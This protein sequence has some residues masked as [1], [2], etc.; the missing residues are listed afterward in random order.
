MFR[1]FNRPG[2]VSQSKVVALH[3][4]A[5]SPAS[6]EQGVAQFVTSEERELVKRLRI[7]V[8]EAKPHPECG[9]ASRGCGADAKGRARDDGHASRSKNVVVHPDIPR[10]DGEASPKEGG[11]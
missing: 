4:A 5:S 11:A 2:E 10:S 3:G 1:N 7:P 6:A 9:E 8:K